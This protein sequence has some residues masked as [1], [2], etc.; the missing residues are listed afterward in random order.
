MNKPRSFFTKDRLFL[1]I[2]GIVLYGNTLVNNYSIDDGYVTQKE[3]VTAKGLS[4]IPELFTSFYGG[5]KEGLQYDYRPLVKISF[6]VEH[7]FFGVNP[8]T[9]HFFNIVLYIVCLFLIYQFL[10]LIVNDNRSR[11]PFYVALLFAFLPIHTEVVAS[12]KNRDILL[13]FIFTLLMCNIILRGQNANKVS[14]A[15]YAVATLCALLA[16]LSKLDVLPFLFILPAIIFIRHKIS[17]GRLGILLGVTGGGFALYRIIQKTAMQGQH[18]VRPHFFFENPLFIHADM[19]SRI[20]S[21]FNSLGFYLVQCVF[22]FKQ[23]CYYGADTIPVTQM[24]LYGYVGIMAAAG[25]IWLLIYGWKRDRSLLIG[26]V[27]FTS[28]ISIYLNFAKPVVGI[29]ADRF[30][31]FASFGFCVAAVFALHRRFD[32][33][34]RIVP[35]V[36]NAAVLVFV[37]YGYMAISRNT[38][39][40]DTETILATDVKKYPSSAYLNYLDAS[41]KL[42]LAERRD[43]Q[44]PR[45]QRQ[46]LVLQAKKE[47]QTSVAIATDYSSSFQLLAR[48][49]IFY[50]K[51]YQGALPLVNRALALKK[52]NELI[53]YKALCFEGMKNDSSEYY[54]KETIRAD[55]SAL[56]AYRLLAEH[57]NSKGEYDKTLDVL[58]YAVKKGIVNEMIYSQLAATYF[59]KRDVPNAKLYCEK[60]LAIDPNNQRARQVLEQLKGISSRDVNNNSQDSDR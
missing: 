46:D 2:A 47:L 52:N 28:S 5:G 3:N 12:I 31:F 22:P 1:M 45:K 44:L 16:F 58:N 8:H 40:K 38:E 35:A 17:L 56:N 15:G 21:T 57:Y 36:R 43:I 23:S 34:K 54:L 50:E 24:G 27:V 7:Q 60:I 10:M 51:D 13:C 9:S 59:L 42:K 49:L 11:I 37:V 33:N 20:I 41:G 19:A 53:F 48:V 39:W 6:A 55:S 25:M 14:I 30:A 29:V 32:L 26:L 18:Q 4:A